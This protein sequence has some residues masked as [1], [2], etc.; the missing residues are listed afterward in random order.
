MPGKSV[1]DIIDEALASASELGIEIDPRVPR[2]LAAAQVIREQVKS[3]GMEVSAI[4]MTFT[5]VKELGEAFSH[6]GYRLPVENRQSKLVYQG[7]EDL[8]EAQLE[9]FEV[10]DPDTGARYLA[11]DLFFEYT[12][13]TTGQKTQ[14]TVRNGLQTAKQEW[15]EY[16]LSFLQR[17]EH[18]QVDGPEK[19]GR[20]SSNP[21]IFPRIHWVSTMD[22]FL[23]KSGLTSTLSRS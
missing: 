19:Q 14:S 5:Q 17:R 22:Q 12:D 20:S 13:P 9:N 1:D 2:H 4:P 15:S 7:L 16:K 8:T 21:N 10:V 11:G 6:I 3:K 18:W 23:Q